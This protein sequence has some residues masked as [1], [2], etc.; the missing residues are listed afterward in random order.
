MKLKVRQVLLT[1]ML[2]VMVLGQPLPS[3]GIERVSIS[4]ATLNNQTA[5]LTGSLM[6]GTTLNLQ[7]LGFDSQPSNNRIWV[8]QSPCIPTG[9]PT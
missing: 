5:P 7:G 3:Y 4:S 6:G 9:P 8:G 1:F 2:C